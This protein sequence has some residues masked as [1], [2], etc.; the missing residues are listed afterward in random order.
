MLSILS[1]ISALWMGALI[2][3]GGFVIPSLFRFLDKPVAGKIAGHIF[4][5]L[6]IFGLLAG[7]FIIM[8]L[9]HAVKSAGR[10]LFSSSIALHA[11]KCRLY[12][13]FMII[14]VMITSLITYIIYNVKYNPSFG[15]TSKITPEMF[16]I[17]HTFSSIVY[18][19][20]TILS[21]ILY[22]QITKL[23]QNT[24]R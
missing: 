10:Q 17:I 9:N 11:K 8:L 19:I 5:N 7:L 12:A 3:I 14:C 20:L 2:S 15:L 23:L 24:Y 6:N 22:I 18:G 21:I 13:L 1:M 16:Q 4:T